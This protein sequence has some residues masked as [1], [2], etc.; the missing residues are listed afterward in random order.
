MRVREY[1][2]VWVCVRERLCVCV[3]HVLY[4][5]GF[6]G[7]QI[8]LKACGGAQG[9]FVCAGLTE[10]RTLFPFIL[11]ILPLPRRAELAV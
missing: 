8:Q 11:S 6:Y 5:K 10:Q 9:M 7:D 3:C 1:V 4:I 2:S